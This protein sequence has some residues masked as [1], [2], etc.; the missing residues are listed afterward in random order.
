MKIRFEY[1]DK[2]KKLDVYP[3]FTIHYLK[4]KVAEEF[5]LNVNYF[6]LFCNDDKLKDI[7]TLNYGSELTI[8]HNKIYQGYV[9]SNLFSNKL[10]TVKHH[11]SEY[12]IFCI[13]NGDTPLEYH[14]KKHNY[15]IIKFL[16]KNGANPNARYY[17]TLPIKLAVDMNSRHIVKLL[18]EFGCDINLG[19][20][21]ALHLACKKKYSNMVELLLKNGADKLKLD[22]EGRTPI[23]LAIMQDNYYITTILLKYHNTPE[24]LNMKDDRG[25]NMFHLAIRYSS[26]SICKK[27]IE[28]GV[29]AR[30]SKNDNQTALHDA[31]KFGF[32]KK[33]KFLL[34]LDFS[35]D[36]IDS[37]ILIS[38]NDDIK[39]ALGWV[40]PKEEIIDTPQKTTTKEE[41]DNISQGDK[42]DKCCIVM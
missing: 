28:A 9:E 25:Y 26:L 6:D 27:L 40:K 15:D 14:I 39:R 7:E 18:I 3:G 17:H 12:N 29:D 41:M 19:L 4:I 42:Y 37:A 13:K 22:N 36:V 16:L 8:K 31:A 35:Q 11:I 20:S 33:I 1:F 38:K 30:S 23:M 5:K 21:T 34:K 24:K 10:D 2:Y 32:E